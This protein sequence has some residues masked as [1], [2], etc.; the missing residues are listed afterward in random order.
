VLVGEI[1]STLVY[2]RFDLLIDC[3]NRLQRNGASLR[4]STKAYEISKGIF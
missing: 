1:T 4:I 3:T 2:G